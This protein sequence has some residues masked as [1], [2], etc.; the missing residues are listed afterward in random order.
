MAVIKMDLWAEVASKCQHELRVA[1]YSVADL[2]Q[3]E[4][5]QGYL[6]VQHRR[7]SVRPRKV[8]KAHYKVPST[9]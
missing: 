5:V 8:H 4:L 1:G 7:V 2:S 3:E 9:L 6:N